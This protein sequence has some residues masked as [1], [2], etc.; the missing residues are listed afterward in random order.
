MAYLKE[1]GR[2]RT[3]WLVLG[4]TKQKVDKKERVTLKGSMRWEK[5]KEEGG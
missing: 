5:L 1:L 3:L 4:G 2:S